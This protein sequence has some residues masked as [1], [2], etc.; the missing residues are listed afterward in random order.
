MRRLLLVRHAP[1]PATR[2]AAFSTDEPLDERGAAEAAALRGRLRAATECIASPAARAQETARLLGLEARTEPALDECD[3]GAWAGRDLEEVT[4]EDP[5]GV[6]RWLAD[7]AAAPH[8]GESL[9]GLLQRVGRWLDAQARLAGTVVAVTHAG[10]IRASV[11]HAL[12]APPEAFWRLDAAPLSLTEL[13]VDADRWRVVRLNVV[14]LGGG[15][16]A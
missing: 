2:R 6:R 8:G 14:N 11:V 13:H 12:G 15:E 4:V 1:T 9:A 3:F 10:P 16:P 7:P 5:D